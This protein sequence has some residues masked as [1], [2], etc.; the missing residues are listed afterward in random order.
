MGLGVETAVAAGAGVAVQVEPDQPELVGE[1]GHEVVVPVQGAGEAVDEDDGRG[2][3]R[4]HRASSHL[5]GGAGCCEVQLCWA[6]RSSRLVRCMGIAG[7]WSR[8]QQSTQYATCWNEIDLIFASPR[9]TSRSQ[10]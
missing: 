3:A 9:R 1:L 5:S 8:S 4:A 6:I 10:L 2:L 7:A